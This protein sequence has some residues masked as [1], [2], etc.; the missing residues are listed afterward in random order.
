ML[1]FLKFWH[2]IKLVSFFKN[3]VVTLVFEKK[4]QFFPPKVEENCDH[5]IDPISNGQ[6]FNLIASCKV[7]KIFLFCLKKLCNNA[8]AVLPNAEV[9]GLAPG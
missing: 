6:K 4:R 7:L 1:R 5:N 3:L 9:V 8:T 2:K